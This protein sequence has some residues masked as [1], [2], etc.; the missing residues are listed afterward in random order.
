MS[1]QYLS[2]RVLELEPSATMAMSA[3][4]KKLAAEGK[5]VIS[6]AVG[7]PDFKTPKHICDAAKKAIDDGKHQY[8]PVAGVPELRKAIAATLTRD[9]GVEF[10]HEQTVAS[11]GGK[12]SIYLTLLT[13]INPGD[14][15]IIPAPYWVSYPEMVR[16]VGG[17]PVIVDTLEEESFALNPAALSKAMTPKTKLLLLNSPA[18]P[19]GQ[20]VPRREIM[21]LG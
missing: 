12:Y 15:V 1:S 2:Q 18:S 17:V 21:E 9:T 11:P 8:T 6:F 13:M 16:L 19:T 14:E 7:E 10:K 4:S 3:K 20:I 5:N